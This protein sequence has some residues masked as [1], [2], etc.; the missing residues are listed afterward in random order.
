MSKRQV[1]IQELCV[2]AY[3][4]ELS[5][6]GAE[7]YAPA[8]EKMQQY[9]TLGTYIDES[10]VARLPACFGEPHP[11]AVTLARHVDRLD[12]G[13][14]ALVIVS[15]RANRPPFAFSGSLVRFPERDGSRV[16]IFAGHSTGFSRRYKA[17]GKPILLYTDGSH[18]R[19]GY[20]PS[21][22]YVL[23]S[24]QDYLTW[25]SALGRLVAILTAAGD[26][27]EHIATGP[28]APRRPWL[29]AGITIVSK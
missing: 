14:A 17:N 10:P 24:W 13:A 6:S 1:D 26:M 28:T 15:A 2:W 12:H 9:A 8:W 23:G 20:Q 4:D 25:H 19:I 18:C 16:R 7:A 29:K 22:E 11:D 21:L 5:K 27:K 3:R